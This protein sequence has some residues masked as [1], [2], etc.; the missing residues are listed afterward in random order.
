MAD[1]AD[2][3]WAI[4]V[5]AGNTSLPP[6]SP[7]LR[8][9]GGGLNVAA[10]HILLALYLHHRDYTSQ[11]HNSRPPSSSPDAGSVGRHGTRGDSS[12]PPSHV[13]PVRKRPRPTEGN[14]LPPQRTPLPGTPPHP[15]QRTPPEGWAS[16]GTPTWPPP[17]RPP[18]RG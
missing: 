13:P 3:A 10:R 2:H 1:A 14:T 11:T 5:A 6:H 4:A 17:T 18:P 7:P 8:H 16:S 15:T 9:S 12:L